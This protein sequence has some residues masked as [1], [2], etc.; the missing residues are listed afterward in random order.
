MS[1]DYVLVIGDWDADGV[2]S[3]AIIYYLQEKQGKYPVAE[4]LPVELVPSGPRGLK[5]KLDNVNRS[6]RVLV[7]LDIPYTRG[8]EEKLKEFKEKIFSE[9]R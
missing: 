3:A 9:K 4:R 8:L 1:Q 2:V 6:P 7:I 5:E